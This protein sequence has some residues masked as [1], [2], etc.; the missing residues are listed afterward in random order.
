MGNQIVER[1]TILSLPGGPLISEGTTASSPD[2]PS[3]ISSGQYPT[4]TGITSLSS[5]EHPGPFEA[6]DA[7]NEVVPTAKTIRTDI[8]DL[9]RDPD[10]V[11]KEEEKEEVLLSLEFTK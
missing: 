9:N 10:V 3:G 5:P 4:D 1:T 6:K 2:L 7:M 8:E 11:V